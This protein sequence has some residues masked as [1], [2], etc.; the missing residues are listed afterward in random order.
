MCFG[1]SSNQRRS[2]L[3]RKPAQAL[4]RSRRDTRGGFRHCQKRLTLFLKTM[5]WSCVKVLL[6]H[7]MCHV[8][9]HVAPAAAASSPAASS[10]AAASPAAAQ[11]SNALWSDFYHYRGSLI[12]QDEF[13][14]FNTTRWQH[15]ITTWRGGND[16]FE[17]YTDRSE[18]RS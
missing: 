16:E 2:V 1:I 12:F 15:I 13:N 5:K 10:P 3:N 14:S 17:Y 6:V 11:E 9:P 8:V 7:V 4:L 18:N